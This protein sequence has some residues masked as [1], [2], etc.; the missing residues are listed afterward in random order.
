MGI[1]KVLVVDDSKTELMFMT[2]LLQKNGFAVRTAENAE[3]AFRRLAEEKGLDLS[4][5]KGSG[6][7]GKILKEDVLGHVE[8]REKIRR[9]V[10]YVMVYDPAK[11]QIAHTFVPFVPP[12]VVDKNL[13]PGETAKQVREIEYADPVTGARRRIIDVGVPILGGTLGTVRV[14]M[15]HAIIDAAAARSGRNGRAN[16][17]M[18]SSS[19]AARISRS[20]QWRIR[21]RRTD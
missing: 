4:Q 15:D 6:P 21:R 18:M 5:V 3:D 16:A 11:T 1:R 7:G 13:V 12:D 17:A 10:A 19:A 9:G 8:G 2:D 20:S 14:G